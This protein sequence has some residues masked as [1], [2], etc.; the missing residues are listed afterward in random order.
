MGERLG[1]QTAAALC[2]ERHPFCWAGQRHTGQP[3]GL[4]EW[5]YSPWALVGLTP[6]SPRADAL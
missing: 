1:K 4:T 3:H 6:P 2:T 5:P